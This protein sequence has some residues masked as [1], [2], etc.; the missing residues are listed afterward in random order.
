MTDNEIL[1]LHKLEQLQGRVRNQTD[2]ILGDLR[3][4]LSAL[5]N[6]KTEVTSER[7][8]VAMEALASLANSMD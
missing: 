5:R 8:E 7:I 3:V 6:G 4:A 2:K 1:A